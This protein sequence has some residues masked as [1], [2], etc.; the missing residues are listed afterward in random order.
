MVKQLGDPSEE[1]DRYP[2]TFIKGFPI[3][4]TWFK[5]AFVKKQ[6][7]HHPKFSKMKVMVDAHL[8]RESQQKKSLNMS[9]ANNIFRKCRALLIHGPTSHDN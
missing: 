8:L 2:V 7:W 1:L 6:G 5:I 9:K 3:K 4:D